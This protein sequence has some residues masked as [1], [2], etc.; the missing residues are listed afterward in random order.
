[1]NAN[2]NINIESNEK[3]RIIDLVRQNDENY[4]GNDTV[5]MLFSNATNWVG[6]PFMKL[7]DFMKITSGH[8]NFTE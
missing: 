1:M 2:N 7:M 6:K 3:K 4:M 8:K 5:P